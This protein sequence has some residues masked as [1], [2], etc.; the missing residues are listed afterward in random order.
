MQNKKQYFRKINPG[1]VSV[2]GRQSNGFTADKK[3]NVIFY[4][5]LKDSELDYLDEIQNKNDIPLYYGNSYFAVIKSEVHET[6]NLGNNNYETL[7][8]KVDTNKI[9]TVAD[10]PKLPKAKAILIGDSQ[11]PY[12]DKNSVQS[13]RLSDK[14]GKASLW[15]GGKTVSWLIEALTEYSGDPEVTHVITVIGTNGGF[16]KYAKDDIPKLFNLIKTKFPK[17]IVLTVQGSW[18][19]GGLKDT[20]EKEVRDYYKQYEKLGAILIEPPI[21]KIEPHGDK[22]VYKEIGKQ[23]DDIISKNIVP[24]TSPPPQADPPPPVEKKI[25]PPAPPVTEEEEPEWASL[26]FDYDP[27]IIPVQLT[28]Q[29]TMARHTEEETKE[30]VEIL[31]DPDDIKKAPVKKT[32]AP[33]VTPPVLPSDRMEYTLVYLGHNQGSAGL[34]AILNY[35]FIEPS[36]KVPTPNKFAS[37]VNIN[38]NMFGFRL[39][40]T[41]YVKITYSKWSTNVG[42]DFNKMFGKDPDTSYTPLNFFTYWHTFKIPST[43]AAARKKIPNDLLT[44]FTQLSGEYG[45]PLDYI[46]TTAYIES[47]FKVTSSNPKYKGLFALSPKEFKKY[48]PTGDIFNK[49]QNSRAGVQVLKERIN[50]AKKLLDK[51]KSYFK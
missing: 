39:N 43:S 30:Y 24:S 32:D 41:K 2:E 26:F 15:E 38:G 36:N 37:K 4:S 25:P 50:E 42:D 28:D 45:V 18:G 16:G 40:G 51:Y 9:I 10:N 47:R 31:N 34:K 6:L 46:I 29:D 48:Y 44:L 7:N 33:P 23:I 17:A 5:G 11:T 19:W 27:S 3:G 14:G 8:Q 1:D 20:T 22:P 21:G 35:S 12:V 13:S 49:E